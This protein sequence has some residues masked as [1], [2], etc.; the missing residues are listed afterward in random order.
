M[1]YVEDGVIETPV[2]VYRVPLSDAQAAEP[3]EI[4]TYKDFLSRRIVEDGYIPECFQFS[5]DIQDEHF[6]L[7]A[8]PIRFTAFWLEPAD[9]DERGMRFG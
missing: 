4:F 8:R 5:T 9:D 2:Y 6:R 7:I 3:S 1:P